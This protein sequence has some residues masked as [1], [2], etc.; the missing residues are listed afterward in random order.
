MSHFGYK[1]SSIFLNT[2]FFAK[3]NANKVSFLIVLIKM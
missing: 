1:D 3:K 2:K